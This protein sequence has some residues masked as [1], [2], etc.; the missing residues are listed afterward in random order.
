MP[1]LVRGGWRPRRRGAV[2][3]VCA[4]LV[5]TGG[6]T[7][8][9]LA[10][11]S[12]APQSKPLDQAIA[13]ALSGSPV[14]GVSADVAVTS[15][16]FPSGTLLG[17]LASGL[18][19]GS[20]HVW[21]SN[22]GSGRM[23]L[24]TGGG[25][26]DAAWDATT[27]SIYVAALNTVYR[28]DLPA[29]ARQSGSGSTA[30]TPPALATIDSVLARIATE[31]T[32][33]QPQ[34]GVVG[35]QPAYSVSVSPKQSGSM[36]GSVK[37]AWDA[38]HGTPLRVAV[39]ASGTASPAL[40]FDVTNITY[41]AVSAS[42]LQATFPST[43]TVTDLGAILHATTPG[44][45][46]VSGLAAVTA[47]AGFPVTAPDSLAGLPR[48]SVSL[49]DR[50]VFIRYGDGISGMLLIERT[51]A[52]STNGQSPLRMLPSVTVNGI[53]AHELTTTLG[54]AVTWDAAGTTYVL[55]GS[56]PPAV[57]ENALAPLR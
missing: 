57:L 17:K 18:L 15:D 7:A 2:V 43:A 31:W 34:P 46:P 50:T 22:D 33:S 40:E 54:T 13:Q 5:L 39:Y 42:D 45:P 27:L 28:V 55:A 29:G 4:V 3:A 56:L 23:E 37:L 12:S 10:G 49:R 35:G 48:S 51:S 36:L 30:T 52:D 53:T 8:I 16:L 19:S 38:D 24:Q 26:V 1:A 6:G 44:A 25:R 20:G 32:I 47:A 11:G 14:A 41:G 9:A 21:L